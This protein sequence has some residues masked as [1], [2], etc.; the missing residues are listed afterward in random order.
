MFY[1]HSAEK[2]GFT[3]KQLYYFNLFMYI[4]IDLYHF[5]KKHDNL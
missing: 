2:R 3:T 1:V 5:G 4:D